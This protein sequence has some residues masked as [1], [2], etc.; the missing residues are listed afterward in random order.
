MYAFLKYKGGTEANDL[1]PVKG[2]RRLLIIHQAYGAFVILKREAIL[3]LLGIPK[4]PKI[5]DL[6][7]NINPLGITILADNYGFGKSTTLAAVVLFA[8][9]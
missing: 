9:K 6:Q 1:I 2:M 8:V 5:S 4:R 3:R 7:D